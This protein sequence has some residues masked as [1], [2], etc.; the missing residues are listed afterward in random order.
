MKLRTKMFVG[1]AAILVAF[2]AAFATPIVKLASPL[3][4]VGNQTA[5]FQKRGTFE[6]NGEEQFSASLRTEGPSTITIQDAAY[7]T[8]GQNGWHSHPG[9][10]IVTVIT[11]SIQWYDENCRPTTYKAGDSWAEGS[12]LH[13]FKVLG[14]TGA[15]LSA[16]FITAQGQAV[17]TDR[18][19]PAC[20]SGL[21]L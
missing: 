12:Q 10:V 15:N 6:N 7:S 2:G 5:D 16:V 9:I 3:L 17:R 19:A 21:G 18:P 1:G 11:G 20:A 4:S 14:T 8:G 13:A